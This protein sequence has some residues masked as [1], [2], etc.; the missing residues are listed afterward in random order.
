MAQYLVHHHGLKCIQG[1]ATSLYST[2]L[3]DSIMWNW[4]VC[5]STMCYSG[6]GSNWSLG[7]LNISTTDTI[8]L[9]YDVL[10]NFADTTL[11]G[12]GVICSNCDSLIFSGGSWVLL[13]NTP[14]SINEFTQ[15]K[16]NNNK[17]YDL[18]GRELKEV[19]VG[20]MYIR[21]QKLYITK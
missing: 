6:Y 13:T 12:Y 7:F 15:Q 4:Q 14:T 9:C 19:P 3:V 17:I 2:G 16:I 8:K 20:S 10:V 1:N 5:N 21:N 11:N 18:L